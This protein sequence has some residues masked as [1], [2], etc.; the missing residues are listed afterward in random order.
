VRFAVAALLLRGS[1]GRR[2]R[3]VSDSSG[4]FSHKDRIQESGDRSQEAEFGIQEFKNGAAGQD[5]CVYKRGWRG[6]VES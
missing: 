6:V 2:R 5:P 1:E 3:Q 4:S